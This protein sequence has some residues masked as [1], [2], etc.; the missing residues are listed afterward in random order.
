MTKK[1][2]IIDSF[3]LIFRAY[4]AFPPT[5][6]TKEGELTNAVYGF[7]S[8]MLDVINKFEPSHVISVFDP[9]SPIIRQTEFTTYKENR[10]ETDPEL[11]SQIPK[12]KDLLDTFDIP[13]IKV[14]GFE[15]DDVIATLCKEFENKI[16]K[17]IVTG[18]QDLFQLIT[19]NTSVYLAGR[20]FSESK[21]FKKED[22][23]NKLGIWPE[24]VPDYKGLAGDASDNIPGVKGIGKKSAES[25]VQ[26][27]G[28]IE[29]IYKNIDLVPN[30]VKNKLVESYEIA[31][32]SKQLA[33]VVPEVP[34]SFSLNSAE[35]SSIKISDVLDLFIKLEFKSLYKKVEQLGEKLGVVRAEKITQKKSDIKVIEYEGEALLTDKIY[36]YADVEGKT[37]SPIDYRLKKIFYVEN[38]VN[39]VYIVKEPYIIH[40]LKN[41][42]TKNII[43]CD[44]KSFFHSAYNAYKD[45]EYKSFEDLGFATQLV[46]YNTYGHGIEDCYKIIKLDSP[47]DGE[48]IVF[49]LNSIH[50]RIQ[51][52]L[53]KDSQI[54]AVYNLEKAILPLIIEM[55]QK[56]I[57]F[58]DNTN[59][60]IEQKL[61]NMK[62]KLQEQ[63]YQEAGHEFNINSPKQVGE[64]LFVEKMLTPQGKTKKGSVSTD[65]KTLTK[66]INVDPIVGKILK[67]R[68]V[69]KLLSTYA[70][71][72]PKFVDKDS[73][74]RSN[75]DQF[76]AV[77]GRFSSNNPNLQNIPI[78]EELNINI[79]DNFVAGE[80]KI[81]VGFDYSQ[82]ELRILAA[83][84]GEDIMINSFNN[85][86]DIHVITASELFEKP[87]QEITKTER[88]VG[89]T[90]NFSIV[91][92]ISSFGLSER[93]Q[94][95]R[96][97]SQS[98][99]DK[100]YLTYPS[101][102][103][104]FEEQRNL[105]LKQMY[106]QTIL[107]R[108]R[109]NKM[110]NSTQWFLRN[111]AEREL[112]NF[113][114]QG[115]AADLMKLCMEQFPNLLKKYKA[116]LLLQIHD[117]FVF[118]FDLQKKSVEESKSLKEFIKEVIFLMENIYN[119]GVDYKVDAKIGER[120]GSMNPVN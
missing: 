74:I 13:V 111:A 38:D 40:F 17:I 41:L 109:M 24:Q 26:Q 63:I 90:I 113:I 5:L 120:W 52:L 85:N 101:I 95:D 15:A 54:F 14:D 81:L 83:L 36:I 99:I 80:G 97:T 107:G 78:S 2:L 118:E 62:L 42:K 55:E 45:F 98:F 82:Q 96:K 93:L 50:Q 1:L 68:E 58:D 60:K 106:T 76:G 19:P 114:I 104:F 70:L 30:R 39:A 72:L 11:I 77:S 16:E 8:L 31:I 10:K 47:T 79:R 61:S 69:D 20:R 115:S 34:I 89:K 12:V 66:L 103:R 32:K 116:N 105:A 22:V 92:G 64:V 59:N 75:F 56:G 100:F 117:E 43:L 65:E 71:A 84:A 3:A 112:L 48:D 37:N 53:D 119:V 73:R 57:M 86:Q 4:Y 28:D 23:K 51:D 87:V 9:Q 35:L 27:F 49:G 94:L 18:D 29:N 6:Q 102:K 7:A 33:T 46:S 21:L 108:K 91:Y 67:Y 110:I 88:G 44:A 25:L